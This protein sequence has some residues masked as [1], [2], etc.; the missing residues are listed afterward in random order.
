MSKPA[1]KFNTAYVEIA[2][3]QLKTQTSHLTLFATISV[4]DIAMDKI[5]TVISQ[6]HSQR[7]RV[8]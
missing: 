8:I 5:I 4:S 3:R 7:E 2:S 6:V 1:T